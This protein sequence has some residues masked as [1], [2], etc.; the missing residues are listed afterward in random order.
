MVPDEAAAGEPDPGEPPDD[1]LEA[2]AE[3]VEVD[4]PALLGSARFVVPFSMEPDAE[5]RLRRAYRFHDQ[6]EDFRRGPNEWLTFTVD[7]PGTVEGWTGR[8]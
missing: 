5:G 2:S 8:L 1:A 4:D 7:G 3:D 6:Y